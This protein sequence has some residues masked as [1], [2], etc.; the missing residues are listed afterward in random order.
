[1]GGQIK[2]QAAKGKGSKFW[3]VLPN[4][5]MRNAAGNN[6]VLN[7]NDAS[8]MF[9]DNV[10]KNSKITDRDSVNNE[11]QSNH[12]R[13]GGTNGGNNPYVDESYE[14]KDLEF[15]D[16]FYESD[17]GGVGGCGLQDYQGIPAGLAM[18]SH[19]MNENILLNFFPNHMHDN[20]IIV[21]GGT[22]SGGGHPN[23]GGIGGGGDEE[24]KGNQDGNGDFFD[25]VGTKR[26]FRVPSQQLNNENSKTFSNTLTT[27]QLPSM[28]ERP[29]THQPSYLQEVK[30]ESKEMQLSGRNEA[31]NNNN[32]MGGN[33]YT[34]H[35]PNQ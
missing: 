1:M 20:S 19:M 22:V 29:P 24:N 21:G 9:T 2:V 14:S 10:F 35:L 23:G 8:Q 26:G 18:T 12:H 16:N 34:S 31:A 7:I 28:I 17:G 25:A 15:E 4:V 27:S 6:E 3:F 13:I 30:E 11:G 32:M 5:P 33:S